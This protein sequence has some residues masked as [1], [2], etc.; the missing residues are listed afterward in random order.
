MSNNL[1]IER[2]FTM[3]CIPK[4]I[5][6][7]SKHHIIQGYMLRKP[8]VRIRKSDDDY[9]LT[10]K[11]KLENEGTIVNIEEEFPLNEEGFY[12]LLKKCDGNIIEK[13]RYKYK[14]P[15]G[16]LKDMDDT[17]INL[18][19]EIDVFSGMFEGLAFCEVE[20]PSKQAANAFIMPD[21]LYM[22]VTKNKEF[23]NGYLS[24]KKSFNILE[25]K[26]FLP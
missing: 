20:F 4:D 24:S 23:S 1:E 6:K 26:Q 19:A 2:K 22:D 5:E 7:A 25:Y 21:W 8:V 12:H 9:I 18:V 3:K 16:S 17:D 11:S 10:Y 13:T 14:L 15:K